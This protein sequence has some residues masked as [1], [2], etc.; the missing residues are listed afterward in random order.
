FEVRDAC[1]AG[2]AGNEADGERAVV[3][4]P[5]FAAR[6]AD[7]QRSGFVLI[8]V[9]RPAKRRGILRLK[10]ADD[11]LAG[12]WAEV[13]DLADGSAGISAKGDVESEGQSLLASFRGRHV[14]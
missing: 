2:V 5:D 9:E 6:P 1:G 13:A 7:N 8:L 3:E 12:H 10:I 14:R 4:I 11:N